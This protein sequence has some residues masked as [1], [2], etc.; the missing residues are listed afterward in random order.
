MKVAVL[1]A[2]AWGTALAT[3]L[4]R[5][6]HAV[7]LWTR[8]AEL[9]AE[10]QRTRRNEKYLPGVEL[11]GDFSTEPASAAD[12]RRTARPSPSVTVWPRSRYF[13]SKGLTWSPH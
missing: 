5:N 10:M 3:V 7:T 13:S 9:L 8:E 2:G 11:P 6:G 12:S 4:L 1:G